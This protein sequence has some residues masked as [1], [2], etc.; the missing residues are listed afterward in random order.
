M[1][2]NSSRLMQPR[3]VGSR[4]IGLVVCL[5]YNSIS[6]RIF[7][8]DLSPASEKKKKKSYLQLTVLRLTFPDPG[9]VFMAIRRMG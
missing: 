5:L 1:E 2:R 6:I 4:R 9:V 3:T 7:F 8:L